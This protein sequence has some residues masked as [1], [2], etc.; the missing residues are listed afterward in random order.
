MKLTK[1]GYFNACANN[2][3]VMEDSQWI[4]RSYFMNLLLWACH[5]VSNIKKEMLCI[6]LE[7]KASWLPSLDVGG[8][9]L[10]DYIKAKQWWV[11]KLV[12]IISLNA[13]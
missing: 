3:S 12:F 4:A 5:V 11:E 13:C 6:L 9:Q 8:T 2:F 10:I 1:G 7:N